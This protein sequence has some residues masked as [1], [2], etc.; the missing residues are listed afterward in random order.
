MDNIIRKF[1]MKYFERWSDRQAVAAR[2]DASQYRSLE[3]PTVIQWLFVGCIL[4]FTVLTALSYYGGHLSGRDRYVFLGFVVFVV[5]G[6]YGWY[7]TKRVVKFNDAGFFIEHRGKEIL[8]AHWGLVEDYSFRNVQEVHTLVL[9]DGRK[10]RIS[11]Y[12]RG[13]GDFFRVL[14][15][16]RRQHFETLFEQDRNKERLMPLLMFSPFPEHSQTVQAYAADPSAA[17]ILRFAAEE[18][19]KKH[20]GQ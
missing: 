13:H 15:L 11:R 2:E 4:F 7:M 16:S 18:A 9:K 1:L 6:V 10:A 20:T 5:V 3:F 19:L 17:P 8:A 12:H 14:W